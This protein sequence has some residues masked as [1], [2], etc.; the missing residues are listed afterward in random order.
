M[1]QALMTFGLNDILIN[2]YEEKLTKNEPD[3]G[4]ILLRKGKSRDGGP[5]VAAT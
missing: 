3:S 5:E 2:K 4:L 1:K